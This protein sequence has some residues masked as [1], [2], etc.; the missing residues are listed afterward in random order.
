[1][2]LQTPSVNCVDGVV[3]GVFLFQL[4]TDGLQD[5]VPTSSQLGLQQHNVQCAAVQDHT[6][7]WNTMQDHTS[8]WNTVQGHTSRRNT[9][10]DHTSQWNT[11]QDHTSRWNTVQD[12]TS[13]WNT[14][15]FDA[16]RLVQ[17]TATQDDVQGWSVVGLAGQ[18]VRLVCSGTCRSDR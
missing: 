8:R 18:I 2:V 13:Q 15:Q 4:L 7:Q 16:S 12:H 3:V 11:M 17:C 9:V 10:Q 6:S 5:V 1:M 14:V